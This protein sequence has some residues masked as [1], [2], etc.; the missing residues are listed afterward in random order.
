MTRNDFMEL[1]IPDKNPFAKAGEVAKK[2][3]G[4]AAEET[5]IKAA[6]A[7]AKKQVKDYCD[8]YKGDSSEG[9]IRL[10]SIAFSGYGSV[11]TG[12]GITDATWSQEGACSA[13]TQIVDE[14][15][16]F[17]DVVKALPPDKLIDIG[18]AITDD[19]KKPTEVIQDVSNALAGKDLTVSG[20]EL[21]TQKMSPEQEVAAAEVGDLVADD[22][23]DN[24]LRIGSN[25]IVGIEKDEN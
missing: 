12:D 5:L 16:V 14:P 17:T 10:P 1:G 6:Q 3:V 24:P 23:L 25:G 7:E 21:D 9:D 13:I 19:T 11:I 4:D 15:K 8:K 20:T 2:I 22:K 18:T